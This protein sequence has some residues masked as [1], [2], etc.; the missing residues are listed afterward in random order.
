MGRL[1]V[2]LGAG[3]ISFVS[4]VEIDAARRRVAA[5]GTST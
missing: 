3:L 2:T 1:V 5:A 4:D